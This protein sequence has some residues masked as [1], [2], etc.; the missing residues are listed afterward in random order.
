MCTLTT[1]VFLKPSSPK[2]KEGVL[3]RRRLLACSLAQMERL[4]PGIARR[5]LAALV[6]FVGKRYYLRPIS[7]GTPAGLLEQSRRLYLEHRR[8]SL[9]LGA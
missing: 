6:L 5:A 1:Y 3:E 2:G 4:A 8:L 9:L 7:A